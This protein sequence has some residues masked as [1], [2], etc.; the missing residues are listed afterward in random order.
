MLSEW[1]WVERF[2]HPGP[3]LCIMGA[4]YRSQAAPKTGEYAHVQRI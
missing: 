4:D 2:L 1:Q 3:C